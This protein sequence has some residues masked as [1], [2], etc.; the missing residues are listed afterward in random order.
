MKK[1]KKPEIKKPEKAEVKKPEIKKS[2]PKFETK[3]SSNLKETIELQK[4]GWV[5]IEVKS[6][7]LGVRPKTWVLKKGV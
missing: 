4:Q 2:E 3:E 6:E 7:Q 1:I 5:V